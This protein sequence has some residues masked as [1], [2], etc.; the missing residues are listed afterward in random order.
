MRAFEFQACLNRDD[1]LKVPE[2]V[3]A[4]VQQ[5]Q[6]VRVILI[7]PDSDEDRGWE[8]LTAEQFLQGYADSDAI[9]DD[10]PAR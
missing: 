2:E 4:E 8:R 6:P 7:V 10:L 1:T 9:Y 3:A 5:E